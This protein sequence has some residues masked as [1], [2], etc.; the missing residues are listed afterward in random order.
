MLLRAGVR[1]VR[2]AIPL[3]HVIREHPVFLEK[4]E[5]FFGEPIKQSLVHSLG[6]RVFLVH[7]I[8]R[9][10]LFFT[11]GTWWSASHASTGRIDILIIS[12]LLNKEQVGKEDDFYFGNVPKLLADQGLNTAIALINHSGNTAITASGWKNSLTPRFLLSGSLGFFHE[13]EMYFR[14]V[15]ESFRLTRV[16]S[17]SQDP[18]EK[19][20][21][22]AASQE[23]KLGA[24]VFNLRLG[25][26]IRNLVKRTNPSTI[27]FTYEGH[28]WERIVVAEARNV[29]KT[30]TCIAYQHTLLF[31]LQHAV[32][33]NLGSAYNPDTIVTAGKVGFD[34]LA[35]VTELKSI[36]LSILGSNRFVAVK[37]SIPEQKISAHCLVIPEGIFTECELLFS[38]SVQCA[39]SAPDI[40]FIW[41]MHPVISFDQ[42]LTS[43]P[44]FKELPANIILSQQTLEED[45]AASDWALY[46]GSTAIIQAIRQGVRGIYYSL[47]NE[48]TIDP[49]HDLT[50]WRKRVLRPE[51]L[52]RVIHTD[53]SEPVKQNDPDKQDAIKFCESFF[54]PLNVKAII[55]TVT[56][57]NECIGLR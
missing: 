40:R 49:L 39:K 8:N 16:A 25:K 19:R 44:A 15:L 22:L 28:A 34:Q 29:Q 51:E 38:F 33:R 32:S 30:I 27:V 57:K 24:P 14:C 52:I 37:N 26:Q 46:R 21:A 47:E 35:K 50:V 9:C 5:R 42:L 2:I 55:D 3:L 53:L 31:R 4:Y 18:L 56:N 48:M 12:H 45:I 1:Q 10:K 7:L 41:R 54:S 11:S 6:I 23:A 36:P 17:Q 20:I 43:Y 13:L